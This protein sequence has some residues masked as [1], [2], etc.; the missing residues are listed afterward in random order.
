[1]TASIAVASATKEPQ[2]ALFGGGGAAWSEYLLWLTFAVPGMLNKG[3]VDSMDRALRSMPAG[4]AMLEIGSF[5]GLST[6]VLSYLRGRIG[7]R[8]PFF[9]CD[10][11]GFEGQVL[12]ARIGDGPITHDVYRTFVKSSYLRNIETFCAADRP[13]TI[14][15][16]SDGFFLAWREAVVASD[17]FGRRVEL[18]GPL[19]FCYIDG[20]H[21][22]AFARRD[23]E[24]TDEHLLEGGFILFDDSA[25]GSTWE[26]CRVVR[27]VLAS[28]RYEVVAKAPNYLVR[29]LRCA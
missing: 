17:V 24:N 27:D 4:G 23:F 21:S 20:N 5:C 25:D 19:S 28:G 10:R 18:G 7:V 2:P 15:L 13:H 1:M 3:N 16:D 9:T 12:G 6:C 22:E 11:W 8:A 26:V 29:K 14:E